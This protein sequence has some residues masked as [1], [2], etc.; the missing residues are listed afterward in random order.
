MDAVSR[1]T[2]HNKAKRIYGICELKKPG[3]K[4]WKIN[5]AEIMYAAIP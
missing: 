2:A 5:Q 3:R 1:I 4:R